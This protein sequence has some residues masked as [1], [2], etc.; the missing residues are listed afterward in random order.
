MEGGHGEG[1][2]NEIIREG[3]LEDQMESIHKENQLKKKSRSAE[4]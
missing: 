4:V 3:E 1:L 2:G